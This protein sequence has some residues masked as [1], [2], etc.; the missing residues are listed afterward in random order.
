M[1]TF[2]FGSIDA[3]FFFP[4]LGICLLCLE[5]AAVDLL[6]RFVRAR[7]RPA[8]APRATGPCRSA[9]RPGEDWEAWSGAE[10]RVLCGLARGRASLAKLIE[11]ARIHANVAAR[12]HSKH[13]ARAS[14]CPHDRRSAARAAF[15]VS[16]PHKQKSLLVSKCVSRPPAHEVADRGAA[17]PPRSLMATRLP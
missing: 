10:T 12:A 6:R 17:L 8:T 9:I 13:V 5:L 14:R 3:S 4:S 15:R 11:H 2:N 16:Y 7:L 1:C